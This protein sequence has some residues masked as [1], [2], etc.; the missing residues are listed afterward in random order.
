MTMGT[1]STMTAIAEAIDMTC[2]APRRFRLPTR[3]IS[4]EPR[5]AA[6]RHHRD[7]WRRDATPKQI[8]TRKAF[9]N[10]IAVAMAMGCS[11][12]AIIHV[13]AQAPRRAGYLA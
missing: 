4:H 7:G 5:N 2:L 9:E 6:A 12:N 13:I 11:T 3:A 10:A 1:A 8:Q